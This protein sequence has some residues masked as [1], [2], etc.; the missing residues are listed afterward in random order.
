MQK[1]SSVPAT[2]LTIVCFSSN[3]IQNSCFHFCLVTGRTIVT[4]GRYNWVLHMTAV[5][6][7]KDTSGEWVCT[8]YFN[9]SSSTLYIAIRNTLLAIIIHLRNCSTNCTGSIKISYLVLKLYSKVFSTWSEMWLNFVA[10][11][12]GDS[13]RKKL[14]WGTSWVVSLTTFYHFCCWCYSIS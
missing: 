5:K 1:S 2:K 10:V 14:M 9:Q 8:S 7:P 4:N 6:C 3:I 11:L 13:P 12:F